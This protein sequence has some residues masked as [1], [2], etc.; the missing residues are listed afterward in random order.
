MD[1]TIY[2]TGNGGDLSLVNGD[3]SVTEGLTNQPYL[4][5]FGGNIEASTTGEEKAGVERFDWFGNAFFPNE[6]DAQL[7]S[8]LERGLAVNELSSKGRIELERLAALDLEY[9][10][11]V[12]DIE[13]EVV[14][15]SD[16]KVS[17][18]DKLIQPSDDAEFSFIWDATKNELIEDKII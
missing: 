11:D 9:L 10:A 8:E 2:E 17:I 5:H 13:S 4:A 15:E 16:D 14:I 3:L 7:N 1:L 6:A 12:A 18:S